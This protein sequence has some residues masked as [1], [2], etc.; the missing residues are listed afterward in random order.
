MTDNND[1][2]PAQ[3]EATGAAT[4]DIEY[5]GKTYKFPASMDDADGD[6]LDAIDDQ[7][8]SHA[9][10]GLL[11]DDGWTAFKAAKP[12]VR[13]YEGL[14]SAYAKKIGLVSAGE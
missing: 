3:I 1:K 12:K 2:T 11:G 14:F 5:A 6:V 10:K 9:L 7:K 8:F 13:D 4:V